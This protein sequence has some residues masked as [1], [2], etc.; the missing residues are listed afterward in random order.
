MPCVT[1]ECAHPDFLSGSVNMRKLLDGCHIDRVSTNLVSVIDI[2][3]IAEA[4]AAVIAGTG[5][6]SGTRRR[7]AA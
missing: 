3:V 1:S 2:T 7:L 4:S 5:N 6:R